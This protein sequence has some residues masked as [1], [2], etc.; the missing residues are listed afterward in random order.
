MKIETHSI[1]DT[2]IAEVTS[3]D[4]IINSMEDGVDLLGSLYFQGFD[5]III[6]EKNITPDFFELKNGMAGEI[7]QKFSNYRVR[8]AVVGDFSKYT[9]QS[10]QD[11][12][13]ESNK[14]K[15]VNFV[16]SLKEALENFPNN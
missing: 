4:R 3:E 16:S 13:Y 6:H 5:R 7:L 14:G 11:F 8:L 15:Q 2:K 12:I 10:V 9:R 1:N